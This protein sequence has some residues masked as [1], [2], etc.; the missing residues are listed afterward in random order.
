[1]DLS[2]F[3]AFMASIK[4]VP[5]DQVKDLNDVMQAVIAASHRPGPGYIELYHGTPHEV[6]DLIQKDG[7]RLTKGQRS[8][9]FLGAT[10]SVDNQ[11]IFLTDSK[12]LA[13]YFG[14]N[15]ADG[16]ANYR[17]L[18]CYVDA[19]HI[20]DAASPPR[21]I[22]RLGLDLLARDGQKYTRI[23][24]HR[25]WWLLDR[26]EFVDAL[27]AR[28]Y[29]GVRFKEDTATRRAAGTMDGHTYFVFDPAS[30]IIKGRDGINTVKDF[31][32][33]LI[34]ALRS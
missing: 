32:D 15:R 1:M 14:A 18:T 9:G 11:G 6:A 2:S 8:L 27:K 34:K 12:P 16:S 23:P 30:I 3:D 5:R 31:Y 26:P 7:F 20:L 13:H 21:D 33:W 29:T 19:T 4:K 22:V 10:Y 25:W 28:G 24:I 17:L